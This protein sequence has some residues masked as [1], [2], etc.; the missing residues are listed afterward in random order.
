MKQPSFVRSPPRV[1]PS[2][3]AWSSAL[4]ALLLRSFAVTAAHAETAA[5]VAAPNV[6]HTAA[7]DQTE[8]AKL[9]FERG[10]QAFAQRRNVEAVYYFRQAAELVPSAEFSYNIGLAYED[11]GDV[12][13][14]LASYRQYLRQQPQS[15]HQNDVR[16]RVSQL[17]ARLAGV[18][19]Q[20]LSVRSEPPGATVFVNDNPV[21]ITPWAGELVPG[22][23]RVQARLP[24][25]RNGQAEITLGSE[26]AS[27]FNLP[28]TPIYFEGQTAAD[29]KGR[30]E[31]S[32]GQNKPL[33]WAL[34]GSGGAALIGGIAFEFARASSQSS[35][36]SADTAEARARSQGA[37]DGKQM[38]SLLLLGVGGGLALS[39]TLMLTLG[40]SAEQEPA[41]TA[42]SPRATPSSNKL[43]PRAPRPSASLGVGCT[44]LLCGASAVGRF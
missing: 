1:L 5:P 11:M 9:L 34:I 23:Y 39:G 15:E 43:L 16:Q 29:A 42:P 25:Y 44:P 20:Q 19:L 6:V 36:D 37:A 2:R 14:A 17:E 22:T 32:L 35:A 26:R 30:S 4:A 13:R 8:R 3:A 18:G 21:G 41:E 28:L 38:A 31:E 7:D 33:A 40:R 24:G 27:D 12:G 10:A